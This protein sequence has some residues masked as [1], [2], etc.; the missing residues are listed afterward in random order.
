[1]KTLKQ[2][3][4]EETT[5]DS[6]TLYSIVA[7]NPKGVIEKLKKLTVGKTILMQPEDADVPFRVLVKDVEVTKESG[8]IVIVLVGTNKF[9]KPVSYEIPR[10][11][12]I[13]IV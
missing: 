1:M 2:F 10:D 9:N 5:L 8:K 3:I 6:K 7:S 11:S 12:E 13:K 4:S